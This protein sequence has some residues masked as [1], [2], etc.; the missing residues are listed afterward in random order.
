[1]IYDYDKIVNI[2][3]IKEELQT[4]QLAN[5][6]PF[7]ITDKEEKKKEV[8]ECVTTWLEWILKV[9]IGQIKNDQNIHLWVK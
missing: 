1:M 8:N 6:T 7:A 5:E 2:E 4:V 3:K 9:R